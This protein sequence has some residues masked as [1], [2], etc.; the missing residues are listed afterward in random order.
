MD[1]VLRAIVCPIRHTIPDD[2]VLAGDGYI[3]SADALQTWLSQRNTSPM[4]G[5]PMCSADTKDSSVLVNLCNA[6]R[7]HTIVPPPSH[8]PVILVN[9]GKERELLRSTIIRLALDTEGI[10]FGSSC[11]NKFIFESDLL[12]FYVEVRQER[13][14]PEV[15]FNDQSFHPSSWKA[16]QRRMRDVDVY[17]PR[18]SQLELFTERLGRA[19]NK[20]RTLVQIRKGQP[21]SPKRQPPQQGYLHSTFLEHNELR[22]YQ[23]VQAVGYRSTVSLCIDIVVPKR[24]GSAG[25]MLN[26][27]PFPNII[28]AICQ[29]KNHFF[30]RMCPSLQPE[31][32]QCILQ[33]CRDMHSANVTLTTE[34]LNPNPR[35]C[36]QAS[37]PRLEHVRDDLM[38]Y[39]EHLWKEVTSGVKILNLSVG[40][41]DN[42]DAIDPT[43][44]TCAIF[45]CDN[46]RTGRN[47]Q[48]TL[49]EVKRHITETLFDDLCHG[50]IACGDLDYLHVFNDPDFVIGQTPYHA[51]QWIR[52]DCT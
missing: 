33:A 20:G 4:T 30:L 38:L 50:K 34:A 37:S 46:V 31:H 6:M 15:V 3:Y 26:M 52:N 27:G 43:R 18:A 23:V 21:L 17:F 9:T 22:C 19:M 51:F 47:Q 32:M 28:K 16:R 40:K 2:P 11:Y 25:N 41:D 36:I 45:D 29:D 7:G 39:V 49:T 8:S 13:V 44:C 1:S 12:A 24:W 10:I 35:A 14:A 5:Q 48:L 42:L